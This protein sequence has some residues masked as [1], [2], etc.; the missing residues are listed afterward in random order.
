MAPGRRAAGADARDRLLYAARMPN[1]LARVDSPENAGLESAAVEKLVSRLHALVESGAVPSAQLA[2]ARAGRIVVAAAAGEFRAA[3]SLQSATPESLY[4]AFSTTK[5]ITSSAIWLLLQEGKLGV[6]DR[7]V[8]HIPEFDTHG[9]EGVLVEHLLTHTAGFP[10][11]PF[12]ALDWD[13]RARRLGRFS[14]WRLDWRPGERF[15]YHGLSSM[16]VLAELIERAS[17][18]D[19]RAFI[20]ERIAGPLALADFY[21][22]LPAEVNSRVADIEEVGEAPDPERLRA[23][24]LAVSAEMVGADRQMLRYNRPEIRAV[25]VPGGGLVTNA[26]SLAMFYQ[27]LLSDGCSVNGDRIWQSHILAEALRV[28]TGDLIDPMT[29]QAA[30]RALGVAIAGDEKRVFRAFS[31]DNSAAAFGHAGAGGQI[32]WADPESGLSFVF[33]TNGFDRDPLAMGLRG[34][35]F[36]SAAIRCVKSHPNE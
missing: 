11:A 21:L 13:D 20:R 25:G 4:L 28:R 24:G 34:I 16:W 36:S 8:D 15:Q 19:F 7:V 22:G 17:G 35:Q 32:A 23:T 14:E 30:N 29:R 12:D 3:G 33:L 1:P 18:R 2:I 26:S 31:P 9:K 5:A 27:A 6:A 10:L